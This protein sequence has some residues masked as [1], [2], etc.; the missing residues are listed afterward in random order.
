M[1]LHETLKTL[2]QRDVRSSKLLPKN[3]KFHRK[4]I[5]SKDEVIKY[6]METHTKALHVV[7]PVEKQE[8]THE[9]I[10]NANDKN[11]KIYKDNK[12]INIFYVNTALDK[13]NKHLSIKLFNHKTAKITIPRRN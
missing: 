7:T 9:K 8:K 4:E 1:G 13:I 12:Y 5:L 11:N 2:E 3:F 6:A 10:Q